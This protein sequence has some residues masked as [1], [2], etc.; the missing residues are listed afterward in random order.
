[1]SATGRHPRERARRRWS[2]FA[3][4]L[5]PTDSPRRVGLGRRLDSVRAAAPPARALDAP[6]LTDRAA[7]RRGPEC[8][9]GSGE[10]AA[11]RRTSPRQGQRRR[12]T[13][14]E[15]RGDP[16]G[17]RRR[18]RR[19]PSS[20]L[21]FASRRA[22]IGRSDRADYDSADPRGRQSS[23][24]RIRGPTRCASGTGRAPLEARAA[25]R[26]DQVDGLRWPPRF[27][28]SR[29][30]GRFR[31]NAAAT[32]RGVGAA[33][34]R[35]YGRL[36]APAR[37]A[38]AGRAP[39]D[40]LR[41]AVCVRSS[42]SVFF[43]GS[44]GRC[45]PFAGETVR[46]AWARRRVRRRSAKKRDP[47]APAR[48]GRPPTKRSCGAYSGLELRPA[49]TD[50]RDRAEKGRNGAARTMG[51]RCA[52]KVSCTRGATA[53][54]SRR[55]VRT[56]DRGAEESSVAPKI[57]SENGPTPSRAGCARGPARG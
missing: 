29:A 15:P 3:S 16:A 17:G 24:S 41:A 20:E 5:R 51:G 7:G 13:A 39:H 9:G 27:V 12:H 55:V 23:I 8:G 25:S 54:R 28:S 57:R 33:G 1:M 21:R 44:A 40:A 19:E 53:W 47:R 46:D 37:P 22:A 14:Q 56:S 42:S 50:H 34:G 4:F 36:Q 6:E 45:A 35:W 26:R 18:I 32:Q 38:E 30:S 43:Q 10:G 49:D 2:P 31:K 48:R 52:G 11:E